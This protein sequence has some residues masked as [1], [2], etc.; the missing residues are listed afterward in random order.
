[1]YPVN[2]RGAQTKQMADSLNLLFEYNLEARGCGQGY[3]P[4]EPTLSLLSETRIFK[5]SN[6]PITVAENWCCNDFVCHQQF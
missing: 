5:A 4:L 3:C 1:M 2:I 6:V